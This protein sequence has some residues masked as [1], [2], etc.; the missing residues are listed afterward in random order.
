MTAPPRR[1]RPRACPDVSSSRPAIVAATAA[2]TFGRGGS[3]AAA[4][5]DPVL[6][7]RRNSATDQTIIE[8]TAQFPI[9]GNRGLFVTCENMAA[10]RGIEATGSHSGV[11]AIGRSE[12]AQFPSGTA[13]GLEATTLDDNGY[14][15]VVD[16]GNG[17]APLL[18]APMAID[19]PPTTSTHR[20]GEMLF[21]RNGRLFVCTAGG[22]PGTWVQLGGRAAAFTA[23]PTVERFVD[24]RTGL[25][26]TAGTVKPGST[27]TLSITGR[28]GQSGDPALQIPDDAVAITGNLSVT[29][30]PRVAIGSF[31]TLWPSGKQPPTPLV[32]FPPAGLGVAG[33]EQLR[34][35]AGRA[36]R[37][38]WH[39]RVQQRGMR[40]QHRRHRVLDRVVT[41]SADESAHDLRRHEVTRA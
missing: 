25:G 35:R 29:G 34:H 19:G 38:P 23:L 1:H 22:F 37:A 40:P 28:N 24:T 39:H 3:A 17:L 14:G 20:A 11:S 33:D 32:F 30:A 26:I 8:N 21:D 9:S 6:I 13:V 31:V 2:T 10:G 7:G 12:N 41:A 5:G 16:A 36:R 15:A 4:S 27:L 18:L